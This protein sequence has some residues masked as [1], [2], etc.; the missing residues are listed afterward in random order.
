MFPNDQSPRPGEGG[1]VAAGGQAGTSD[2]SAGPAAPQAG[3]A[4]AAAGGELELLA[5]RLAEAEARA[6]D[7]YDQ[8]VRARAEIENIRRRSQEELAKAHKYAVETFAEAVVPVK[9][10]LEMALKSDTPTIDSIREGVQTTLRQLASA[11][12]KNQ[13]HEIDPVGEKFDPNLHQAISTVPVSA[14]R[15]PVAANHVV[16][17]LQKGYLINDRVLRPALVMV[18][19]G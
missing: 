15:P 3:Q 9:D 18:A 13:L 8:F 19:Q 17:V 10:S 4:D 2:S 6:A 11:F 1:S 12:E 14:T 5:R 16:T 7:H